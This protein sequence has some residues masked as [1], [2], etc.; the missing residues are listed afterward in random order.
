MADERHE[1]ELRCRAVRLHQQ[2]KRAGAIARTLG[3]SRFW[4]WK[5]LRAFHARAWAGLLSGSRAPKQVAHRTSAKVVAAV[6]AVRAE[7]EAHQSRASRF[8]GIGAEAIG[9]QLQRRRVRPLPGLR[10]IERILKAHGRSGRHPVRAKGGS[11]PYPAPP[12]RR[13][14]DLQ[15]TDLV[16][17]RHLRGPRGITRFYSFH[18]VA[19]VGRAV[20]TSQ[21]R[22]KSAEALCAHLVQ[23]WDWL[24][25]PRVSQMD[26]EM[27]ASGGG[28]HPYAFSLVMRLHLLLGVH[29]VFIPEGEPGRNP[30]VESFNDLWQERVLQHPCADLRALRRTDRA[31]LH[32]YHFD[33]PHRALHADRDAT[34]LPGRWL[35]RHRGELGA[36]PEGF[37]LPAYR[38]RRGRLQLPLARGRVSFI[39]KVNDRGCIQVNGQAYFIGKRLARQYVTATVYPHRR[40]LVVK[41]ERRVR[42][43]FAFP[44]YERLVAPLSRPDKP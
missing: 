31:F 29:L 3:R 26:N 7:L 33:K 37:S 23:A 32:Y 44:V 20:A 17:P 10:T 4:V 39:R 38:D 13:P 34:R 12:A 16:G 2:G 22:S 24:G 11:Q 42:K 40:A 41:H 30:H 19:V 25:L 14:G 27:A 8:A 5:W 6:L 15:Q 9:L 43:R 36:L 1:Y 18:T 35:E 28:R 21:A